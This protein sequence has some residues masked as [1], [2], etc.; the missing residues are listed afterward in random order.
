[1]SQTHEVASFNTVLDLHTLLYE[2]ARDVHIRAVVVVDRVEA[3]P[4]DEG[5]SECM[6]FMD[7]PGILHG[8]ANCALHG[9]NAVS[10]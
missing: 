6:K 10:L 1:M 2:P 8:C 5:G 3:F 9:S 7:T 4:A